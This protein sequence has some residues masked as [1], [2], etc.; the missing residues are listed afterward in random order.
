[1]IKKQ[2]IEKLNHQGYGIV[3]INNKVVF[4]QNAI[5]DDVVD[6]EI[7]SNYKKYALA[8]VVNYV[9]MSENHRNVVCP[10]YE[11]CGGCNISHMK[12]P[13]QL[14]FKVNKVKDI[15]KRYLNIDI[16]PKIECDKEFFY[17]NKVVFHVVDGKIG[18]YEEGTN[19]LIN[20]LGC[21]LLDKR[22]NMLVPLFNKLDLTNIEK[23]MVRTTSKEV[24]VVFYGYIDKVDILKDKVDSIILINIKDKLLHGKSYIKEEIN[25]MKFIISYNSFFQ[26]NTNVM[27]KLY[28]KVLEYASLTGSESVLDLYCGTGTIGLYLSKNARDVMGIEVVEDAIKD[29]NINKELNGINNI[30]FVC[31]DVGNLVN[32]NY[33]ADVVI[34]DPPRSGL[35]ENTRK[36]LLENMYERIIYVS[37]DPMTLVRDLRDLSSKYEIKDVCLFDM[38]AN[39]YHVETVVKLEISKPN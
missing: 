4:V 33:V 5:C 21:R 23:I 15:F 37:C 12:Y 32:N 18:F 35:S 31:G 8:E 26:V 11:E 14:E 25:G 22:I 17:R 27:K 16:D 20:I 1:M 34:V 39:T 10:Y 38:F 28:D 7:I 6:I 24:M 3:R 36:V 13:S 29:A 19:R 9:S 30:E 2:R